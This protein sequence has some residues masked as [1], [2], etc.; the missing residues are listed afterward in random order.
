MFCRCLPETRLTYARSAQ[1][2]ILA[3]ALMDIRKWVDQIQSAAG[4]ATADAAS[5]DD[6]NA[7]KPS[8]PKVK[9]RRIQ[10]QSTAVLE[11]ASQFASQIFAPWDM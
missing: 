9:R 1:A 4:D 3:A 7:I 6:L 10:S 11:S 5:H 8:Q 2:T